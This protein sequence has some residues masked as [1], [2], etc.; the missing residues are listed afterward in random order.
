M[1]TEVEYISEDADTSDDEKDTCLLCLSDKGPLINSALCFNNRQCQ[2]VYHVHLTCLTSTFASNPEFTTKCLHCNLAHHPCGP[3]LT[4]LPSTQAYQIASMYGARRQ[5]PT[6]VSSR[7]IVSLTMILMLLGFF[8][9]L[10]V[11]SKSNIETN[12]RFLRL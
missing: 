1:M 5:S 10:L 7:S 6:C 4:R 2:C 11:A 3:V 8:L 9:Y 12:S